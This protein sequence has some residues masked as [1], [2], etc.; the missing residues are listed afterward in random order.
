MGQYHSQVSGQ[1]EDNTFAYCCHNP[2]DYVHSSIRAWVANH[3][4]ESILGALTEAGRIDGNLDISI[5]TDELN[6]GV[7]APNHAPYIANNRF[8]N[9]VITRHLLVFFGE[10]LKDNLYHSDNGYQK[11]A[12]SQ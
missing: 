4:P 5:L 11:G 10:D 9:A 12:E 2:T 8:H 6:T 1:S 3:H 7:Q